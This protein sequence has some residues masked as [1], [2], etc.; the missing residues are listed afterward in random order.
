M[1][2]IKGQGYCVK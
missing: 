1:F 2:K